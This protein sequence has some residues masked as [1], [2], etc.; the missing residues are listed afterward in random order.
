MDKY[1]SQNIYKKAL[2]YGY[3][4]CGIIPIEAL[5]IYSNQLKERID[6]FPESAAVYGFADSYS[7]LKRDYPWAKSMIVCT[8]WYGKYRFP[9]SLQGRYAKAFLLSIATAPDSR[10]H[11]GK[12]DFE[13]W[14]Y[15]NGIHFEGGEINMPARI[16]PLRQAAVA[17]GLGIF[18]KNNF[19]YGP[20]GSWYGLEG[21]LIDKSC[22]Y[23]QESTLK[24]CAE[25]CNLCQKTCK[26]KALSAPFT[27]NPISCV[28]FCTTFG[29]GKI[30]KNLLPEQF[31]EWILGCDSC[32]DACP[33]NIGHDWNEGEAFP[34]LEEIENLLQPENII[35]ASDKEII[36]KVIPKT[37]FHLT[38]AKAD[39]LRVSAQRVLDMKG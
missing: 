36:E 12:E 21:Y 7:H 8:E 34:G 30:P 4:N 3:D 22:E 11:K 18:R 29:E 1:L 13:K 38:A 26:T 33:Y 39:V 6:K 15:E 16:V 31:G 25:K 17:A 35:S 2:E 27:M 32:Q 28:S 19:F 20:K 9:S 10:E 5:D 37:E 24:P 23:I 14:M